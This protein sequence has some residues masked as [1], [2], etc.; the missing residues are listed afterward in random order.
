MVTFQEIR[1]LL[2]VECFENII[3][4]D[5]FLLLN[6]LN[7][8]KHLIIARNF[9]QRLCDLSEFFEPLSNPLI[10]RRYPVQPQGQLMRKRL[11]KAFRF[12]FDPLVLAQ[13]GTG[14][15]PFVHKPHVNCHD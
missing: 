8:S 10:F 4:E 14:Q 9:K 3:D 15:Q 12:V 6:N 2:A 1:D 11:L 5:E 7:I 13:T